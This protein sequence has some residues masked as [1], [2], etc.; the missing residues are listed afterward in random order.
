M[1]S[2]Q[3][4]G[5]LSSASGDIHRAHTVWPGEHNAVTPQCASAECRIFYYYYYFIITKK[6]I[7]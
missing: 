1:R 5:T 2:V 6:K 7:K 3:Y 4:N